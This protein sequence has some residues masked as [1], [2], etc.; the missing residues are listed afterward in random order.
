MAGPLAGLILGS[1]DLT[2]AGLA[3]RALSKEIQMWNLIIK[4]NVA[5]EQLTAK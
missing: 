5:A 1:A 2:E 3:A 4:A